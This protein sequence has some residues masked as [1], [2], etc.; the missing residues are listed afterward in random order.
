MN[1]LGKGINY[2][3]EVDLLNLNHEKQSGNIMKNISLCKIVLGKYQPA[4][5]GKFQKSLFP[6]L[7]RVY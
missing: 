4:N 3:I 6:R 1:I 2:A 7:S 5:M